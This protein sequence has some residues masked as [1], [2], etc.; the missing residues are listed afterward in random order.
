MGLFTIPANKRISLEE[1]EWW[2]IGVLS[3]CTSVLENLFPFIF[4]LFL[5][6]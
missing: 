6:K 4:V 5:W 2:N 1:Y 3:A